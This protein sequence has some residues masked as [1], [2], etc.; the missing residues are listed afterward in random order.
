MVK[1]PLLPLINLNSLDRFLRLHNKILPENELH[2]G[3]MFGD[4]DGDGSLNYI[5]FSDL[6][7]IGMPAPV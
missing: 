4:V 3:I 7:I 2:S 6:L 1:D 5:E